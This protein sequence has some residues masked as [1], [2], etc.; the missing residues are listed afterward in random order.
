MTGKTWII[1][2][3][4]IVVLFGG[5]IWMSRSQQLNVDGVDVFAVQ[6]ASES[7]GNIADHTEG[8]PNAK[9]VIIE[10]ADYQCPGCNAAAPAIRDA[11][12]KNK[13]D[14]LLVYRNFPLPTLHPNARA[15]SAAAEAA[16]LQ[17]KFWEMHDLLFE[18]KSEWAEASVDTR[19]DYFAG[20]AESLGLNVDQF[21]T[22]VSSD[23]VTK[24]IDYDTALAKKQGLSGT[25]SIFVNKELVNYQIKDG[26]RVDTYESGL[27]YVWSTADLFETYAIKPAIETANGSSN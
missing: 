9:V 11:V 19:D 25:P 17:G 21:K 12:A 6:A 5:L 26:K 24:K 18:N 3:G 23:N 1:F 15:A 27:S 14:V 16:G 8:N 7:N 4:L 10:Y 22:D 20:Y 2:A 13:D